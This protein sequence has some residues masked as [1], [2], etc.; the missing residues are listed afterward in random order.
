[1]R[2]GALIREFDS[3][4]EV[5]LIRDFAKPLPMIVICELLGIAPEECDQFR[6]WTNDYFAFV[7]NVHADQDVDR[8]AL[9][10]IIAATQHLT[11]R[12]AYLRLN[13]QDDLLRP[14]PERV[15]AWRNLR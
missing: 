7:G 3:A 10:S 1:M 11:S 9:Q 8:R 14:Y 6:S 13:P 12:V 4:G 2:N 15:R 5:D